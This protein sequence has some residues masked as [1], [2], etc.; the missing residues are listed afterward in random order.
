MQ[1]DSWA[2]LLAHNLAT[3]CLDH[4]PKVKVAIDI[5]DVV[6]EDLQ[7]HKVL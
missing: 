1:H 3:L 2:S 7:I 5:M 4:E 6:I